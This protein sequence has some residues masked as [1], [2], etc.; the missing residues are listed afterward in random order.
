MEF[1]L[2][3]VQ[4]EIIL[5]YKSGRLPLFYF[6]FRKSWVMMTKKSLEDYLYTMSQTDFRDQFWE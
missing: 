3:K 5:K 6:I 4:A 1:F 2:F